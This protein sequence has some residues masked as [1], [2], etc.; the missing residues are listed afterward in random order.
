MSFSPITGQADT[1]IHT[2]SDN[3]R[4]GSFS[5]P[6]FD[7]VIDAYY[8]APAGQD[9]LPVL[10]VIQEIFGLHEHIRDVCRRFANEGYFAVSVELY[11]R[12]GDASGYTDIPSLIKDIV[13]KVPDEQVLADL[14][15][16]AKWAGEQGADASRVGVTGFCWGGRLAWMYAAHN[17]A[18]KAGV[19]WYG[20][21]AVGHGPLQTQ[22]PVD[23]A[24]KIHG[25]MLGLYGGQD[26]SI[27]L[28]DVRRIEEVLAA[29]NAAAK[30]SQMVVYPD[31]GHAFYSDY[32]PSYR[33]DD[34]KDGWS[35]AVAWLGKYLG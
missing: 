18:C 6:T 34:A 30:A 29:G 2:S 15:A 7:G 28:E 3:L 35:R 21:L 20:K 14:D 1:T 23:V 25:P 13:S 24:G 17:P 9:N 4:E 10:L 22:N 27:P 32:R 12:Q 11:Q 16:A 33:A 8:A 31:A 26:A 19:A 5:L